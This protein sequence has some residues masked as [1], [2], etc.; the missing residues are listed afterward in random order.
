MY[1]LIQQLRQ[2]FWKRWS[3]DYLT[4]LQQRNKEKRIAPSLG[5]NTMAL[6]K[7]NQQMSLKLLKHISSIKQYSSHYPK[8]IA[9]A[10]SKVISAGEIVLFGF[11]LEFLLL[12]IIK[13]KVNKLIKRYVS[14]KYLSG[15]AQD[16]VVNN[17]NII[18]AATTYNKLNQINHFSQVS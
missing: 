2:R 10:N 11:L 3:K 1:Q 12:K 18:A 5:I 16:A 15:G 8:N 9:F 13:R 4:T 6:I 17:T 7:D 14:R